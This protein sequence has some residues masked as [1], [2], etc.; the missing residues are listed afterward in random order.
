MENEILRD[1]DRDPRNCVTVYTSLIGKSYTLVCPFC[2]YLIQTFINYKRKP[3]KWLSVLLFFILIAWILSSGY[4]F[5]IFSYFRNTGDLKIKTF[6]SL[7]TTFIKSIAV[8]CCLFG[9][10]LYFSYKYFHSYV[11]QHACLNCS[12]VIGNYGCRGFF[13]LL[14]IDSN[15]NK[16]ITNYPS[17]LSKFFFYILLI[18]YILLSIAI[19]TYNVIFI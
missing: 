1:P 18:V 17:I 10:L 19:V 15:F 16:A 14:K 12:G 3:R 9:V 2:H 6:Y 13:R 4:S 11:A 5:F 7:V 8:N